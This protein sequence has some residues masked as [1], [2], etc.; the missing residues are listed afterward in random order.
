MRENVTETVVGAVVVAVAATRST[1]PTTPALTL[2]TVPGIGVFVVAILCVD[3]S[4]DLNF[5]GVFDL[6][7][8][9]IAEFIVD[10][11]H[12]LRIE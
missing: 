11:R 10:I 7:L 2:A 6:I 12:G 8:I 9:D 3:L 4:L 5:D 1:T